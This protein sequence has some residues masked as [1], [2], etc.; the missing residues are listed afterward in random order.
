MT[1]HNTSETGGSSARHHACFL[2][3]G[4]VLALALRASLK[5]LLMLSLH[6]D[7]YSQI[8]FVLLI[9]LGLMYLERKMIFSGLRFSP[10]HSLPLLLA[11]VGAYC[12]SRIPPSFDQTDRLS[13]VVVA[14]IAIWMGGFVLC[15]G[16]RSFQAA[17]F[18]LLFLLL[19]IPLPGVILGR[20]VFLL[21]KGS[22]AIAYGLFRA[23]DVPVFWSGMNFAL[24]GVNIEVARECS[25]IRSSISL[26]IT[27]IL[28][29]H[30]F[31][32]SG[33]RKLLFSL[34]TIPVAIFKNALRI[35][36]I[37]SLGVYVDRSFLAG[38]LHQYGG[39]PFTLVALAILTP[40]LLTLQKTEANGESR[41][42]AAQKLDR[43]IAALA[44]RA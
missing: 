19:M 13:L 17:M 33:W 32:R 2:V 30:I 29:S 25:G 36:T 18:P 12:L 38:K 39:V 40:V 23:F 27:G 15:Y 11:G 9:S 10:L 37:S 3:L 20:V 44:S 1:Q 5:A 16:S 34:L 28:G 41:E 24:P 4:I 43:G 22:A 8:P 21:Q 7:Q 14:L 31:L 26:L 35:V 42:L 6:D